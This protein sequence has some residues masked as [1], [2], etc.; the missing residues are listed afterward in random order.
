MS[1]MCDR[2]YRRHCFLLADLAASPFPCLPGS[3]SRVAVI[4]KLS[5]TPANILVSPS[6]L[7]IGQSQI[8]QSRDTF[9]RRRAY[10]LTPIETFGVP[11]LS[12][13]S[14]APGSSDLDLFESVRNVCD[15]LRRKLRESQPR[16]YH[17]EDNVVQVFDVLSDQCMAQ[18]PGLRPLLGW[19]SV[20]HHDDT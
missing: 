4:R 15:T 18:C 16:L 12:L 14:L 6:R 3:K 8:G 5:K 10:S 1:L 2:L 20:G 11:L 13:R 19:S 7:E 17:Y 9:S